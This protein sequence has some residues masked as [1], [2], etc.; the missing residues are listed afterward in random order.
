MVTECQDVM[1]DALYFDSKGEYII[2]KLIKNHST[3]L[4][5]SK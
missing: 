4:F 5:P 1:K 2:S 3:V